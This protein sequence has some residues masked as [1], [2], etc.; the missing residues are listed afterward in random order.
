MMSLVIFGGFILFV[1]VLNGYFDL[2]AM[3]AEQEKAK[4]AETD[5]VRTVEE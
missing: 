3:K 1:I 5:P 4:N 2:Q